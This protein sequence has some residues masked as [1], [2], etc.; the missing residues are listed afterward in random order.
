MTN[1]LLLIKLL[2][3]TTLQ[4]TLKHITTTIY[5]IIIT[6][7]TIQKYKLQ[8][9]TTQNHITKPKHYFNTTKL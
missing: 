2:Q 4:K 9:I 6:T 8:I 1:N 3:K 5:K 7:K